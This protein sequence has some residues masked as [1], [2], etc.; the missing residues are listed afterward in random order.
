MEEEEKRVVPVGLG[1]E[2]EEEEGVGE[3]AELMSE[4]MLIM[5]EEAELT[6]GLLKK[7]VEE[8]R[9][10]EGAERKSVRR[11]GLIFSHMQRCVKELP[12]TSDAKRKREGERKREK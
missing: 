6:G 9:G 7:E 1:V 10:G 4:A 3:M 11:A 2:V 8:E 12:K 5:E